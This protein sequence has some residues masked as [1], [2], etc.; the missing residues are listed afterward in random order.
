MPP[1][2]QATGCY[3]GKNRNWIHHFEI[4]YFFFY[5]RNKVFQMCENRKKSFFIFTLDRTG[6]PQRTELKIGPSPSLCIY[7]LRQVQCRRARD[8]L[9]LRSFPFTAAAPPPPSSQLLHAAANLVP[10]NSGEGQLSQVCL[11]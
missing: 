7:I 8:S 9:L 11:S 5:N 1:I 3:F 10:Y 2:Q 4:N 6:K